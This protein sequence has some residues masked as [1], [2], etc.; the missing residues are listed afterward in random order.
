M[1]VRLWCL[2]TARLQW[3]LDFSA[4]E[5]TGSKWNDKRRHASSMGPRLF[6]RGN[7][8]APARTIGNSKVFNGASTFQPRKS[9]TWLQCNSI[10]EPLQWGL[11]FSA[12]EIAEIRRIAQFNIELQWG[13]DFS[14]EEI[15]ARPG[16]RNDQGASFN[17][18]STFQPRK[19][20]FSYATSFCIYMLQW[21]LDFSAEEMYLEPFP[22]IRIAKGFNGAS[23]FQPRKYGPARLSA[24]RDR[25]T[26]MGPRLFSRGNAT[27]HFGYRLDIQ[28]A[29]MGPRL[30]SRGNDAT[31]C[32]LAETIVASMGPRL[33]SRGNSSNTS[34]FAR[35]TAMLQWGLDFSAE[36]IASP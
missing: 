19:C 3:G 33:F 18:A 24:R 15:S 22:H 34:P 25:H 6:S 36:E 13:L 9:D 8:E 28:G 12:E 27:G 29:S 1:A 17:G 4:E 16:N 30:F 10:S 31:R 23:T 5:I 35:R 2:H 20:C 21:G 7:K 26:S 11:D 14:A 32:G